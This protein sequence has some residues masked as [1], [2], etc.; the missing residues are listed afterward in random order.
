LQPVFGGFPVQ[1]IQHEAWFDQRGSGLGIDLQ[2]TVEVA[3]TIH[4]PGPANRLT[5]QTGAGA[6]DDNRGMSTGA[7]FDDR[8][9]I[10][11]DPWK[12]DTQRLDLIDRGVGAIKHAGGQISAHL[13]LDRFLNLS[14]NI[15]NF[16][17]GYLRQWYSLETSQKIVYSCGPGVK[18]QTGPVIPCVFDELLGMIPLG[19]IVLAR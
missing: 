5:G 3:G 1:R 11:C 14:R 8:I 10:V 4:Y 7:D 6:P 17:L 15:A 19:S 12:D 16:E 13:T 9:Q 2:Q 18:L